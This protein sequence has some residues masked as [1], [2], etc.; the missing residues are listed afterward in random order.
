MMEQ[1]FEI[2]YFCLEL[3]DYAYETSSTYATENGCGVFGTKPDGTVTREDKQEVIHLSVGNFVRCIVYEM[4]MCFE[5][6]VI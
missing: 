3:E 2:L 6:K 4:I 1:S 5:T